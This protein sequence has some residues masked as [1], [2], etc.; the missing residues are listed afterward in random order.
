MSFIYEQTFITIAKSRG[1]GYRGL[2]SCFPQIY[3][4]QLTSYFRYSLFSLLRSMGRLKLGYMT[5]WDLEWTMMLL[6][7]GV[8]LWHI[9]QMERGKT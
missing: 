1:E 8:P 5:A 7:I 2:N 4:I 9:V 6:D 3:T